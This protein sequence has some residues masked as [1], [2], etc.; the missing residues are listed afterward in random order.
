MTTI[1]LDPPQPRL[2]TLVRDL[3]GVDRRRTEYVGTAWIVVALT[4]VDAAA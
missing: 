3:D 4:P 1:A 2:D